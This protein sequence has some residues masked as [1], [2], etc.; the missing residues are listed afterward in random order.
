[1]YTKDFPLLKKTHIPIIYDTQKVGKRPANEEAE[2]GPQN[3]RN[4]LIV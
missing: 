2:N 1:M 4:A 3:I